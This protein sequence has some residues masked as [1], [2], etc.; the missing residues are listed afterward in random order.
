[1]GKQ[2]V[3]PAEVDYFLDHAA[4]ADLVNASEQEIEEALPGTWDFLGYCSRTGDSPWRA[5]RFGTEEPF[6]WTFH[7]E[8]LVREERP[9]KEN[10]WFRYAVFPEHRK[11]FILRDE[12]SGS[13]FDEDYFHIHLLA[14]RVLWLF[15]LHWVDSGG[16]CLRSLMMWRREDA[17]DRSF[18]PRSLTR[19]SR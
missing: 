9:G 17:R 16:N 1:M 18:R 19:T 2:W 6:R 15:D 14:P 4:A 7:A 3:D 8:G 5:D 10:E 11:L 12:S 13:P